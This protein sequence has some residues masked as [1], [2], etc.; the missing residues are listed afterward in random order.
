APVLVTFAVIPFG[1]VLQV[2]GRTIDLQAAPL[3]VG[4]LYVLAMA[5]LGVYG[6]VLAGWAS[7]NRWSLLGGIRGSA[8][9][10]S[11]EVA[12]GLALI[13]VLI[14]YGTLDLQAI[15]RAQ[16]WRGGGPAA[17]GGRPPVGLPPLLSA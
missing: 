15:L 10:I 3:N 16:V 2:G 12:L 17:G 13:R 5:S 7:N 4:I 9:M 1:D 8:Q 6:V 14:V 11:Y